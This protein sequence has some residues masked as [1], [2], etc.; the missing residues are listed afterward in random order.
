[1]GEREL[2]IGT[3]FSN[4]YTAFEVVKRSRGGSKGGVEDTRNCGR[5]VSVYERSRRVAETQLKYPLILRRTHGGG[6]DECSI[7]N[8][9]PETAST[10]DIENQ[11]HT[12]H[13]HIHRHRSSAHPLLLSL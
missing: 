11:E 4:L 9:W 1:M 10:S 5:F 6:I 12:I 13:I 8:A 3:Q 2:F 7:E